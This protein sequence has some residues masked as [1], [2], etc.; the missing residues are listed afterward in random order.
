MVATA[1]Q[2]TRQSGRLSF[3]ATA[4]DALHHGAGTEGNTALLRVQEITT[5]D[6]ED[7]E[8]PFISGNSFK[9]TIREAGVDHA[10]TAMGVA[11]GS[12]TKPVVDL[13]F[14]G[15]HLSKS[16]SAVNLSKARALAE[17]F[18]ILGVCGYS[19]GNYMA[20]SKLSVDNIHLVCEENAWRLPIDAQELP[21]A[22]RR[23]GIFRGETFGTRHE[24]SRSP[25]VAR[26]LPNAERLK[27]EGKVSESLEAEAR[28]KMEGTSQMIYDS[29]IIKP[30]AKLWGGLYYRDLDL[31]ELAAL[32]A[33]L[34]HAAQDQAGDGGLIY[35]LGAKRS[36]GLGRVSMQWSGQIRGI[37]APAMAADKSLVPAAGASW[38]GAYVAHLRE[39]REEI[40]AALQGAAG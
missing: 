31:M 15:G 20:H 23:S 33:S 27:L 9:H 36:I 26:L 22:R 10:L 16:G 38:D 39:R 25:H 1:E 32:K 12:L 14:S 18:P 8:V 40:L 6:G 24:A 37:I 29:E 5:P 3:I 30:G 7:E 28:T 21:H 11:D 2:V 17:L 34:S 4:L 13:L 35:Y 19:A